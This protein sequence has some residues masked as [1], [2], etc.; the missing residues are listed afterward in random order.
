MRQNNLF[1]TFQ[2]LMLRSF[3]GSQ[4]WQSHDLLSPPLIR[5]LTV[6]IKDAYLT[7]LWKDQ[8]QLG[9][10]RIWILRLK[11]LSKMQMTK[12][13][14][15]GIDQTLLLS[16]TCSR[17][18]FMVLSSSLRCGHRG[19]LHCYEWGR[20]LNLETKMLNFNF[21]FVYVP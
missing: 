20:V 13:N 14:N 12:G 15:S 7:F 1:P 3:I 19:P 10:S 2:Y 21:V 5:R 6:T 4:H 16:L 8:I 9:Y 17:F 11:L 18:S